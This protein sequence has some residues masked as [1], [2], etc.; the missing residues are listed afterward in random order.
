MTIK[1]NDIN[2]VLDAKKEINRIA[3]HDFV[4]C[5]C[6]RTVHE[7]GCNPDP[8]GA[9][10][11]AECCRWCDENFVIPERKHIEDL[12]GLA[13]KIANLNKGSKA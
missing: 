1:V 10:G 9:P 6:G 5:I 13:R 3:G 2:T 7:F 12:R 11:E 4:C 8:F